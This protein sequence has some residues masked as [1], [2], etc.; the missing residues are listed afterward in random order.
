MMKKFMALALATLLALSTLTACGGGGG[1]A[2]VNDG[3][4]NENTDQTTFKVV[5]GISALSPGYD[6][7]PVL[8][9]MQEKAGVKIEWE[10]MADSLGEQVSIRINGGD[11][12][13]AFQAVGFSNYDLARYGR[14]GTFL[15]LTPYIT[16]E[17]MPN[18]AAILEKY[19][20]IKAAIMQD[21]GKIYGLPPPR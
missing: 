14:G 13:D 1:K 20:K 16:P 15:D 19:P 2:N 11:L 3:T 6:D 17:V 21:D 10:T 18:L 7:N 8:N 9:E 12:P 5:S 4:M